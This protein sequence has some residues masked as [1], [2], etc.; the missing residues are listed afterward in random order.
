MTFSVT[1][2]GS[3]SA[4]PAHG[5]HPTA[6][7]VNIHEHHFL[8]DCGEGTQI[9][10]G[11]YD[12]K[13]G[14]IEQIFIS[15]LH[16]DHYFGLIGLL[17]SYA[18]NRRTTPMTIF[19]PKGL[20]RCLAVHFEETASQ[21]SFPV[22]FVE[23]E[24]E[25]G[26]KIFENNAV[27]VYT[28]KMIHRLPCTGFLF[29][30][31]TRDR[32][33]IPEKLEE[34]KIPFTEIPAI[35]KGGDYTTPMGKLIK[36]SKLTKNPPKPRSYAYCTDTAYNEKLI[37]YIKGVDLLY[38]EATFDAARKERAKETGHS[39]SIQAAMIAKKATVKKLIMG[40]FSARFRDHELSILTDEAATIFPNCALALEGETFTV[41]KR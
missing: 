6:Q 19:G 3:N 32:N 11:K 30:E 29:V 15:H 37:P 36:N 7:I 9:Q 24:D 28:M 22:E 33:V 1:I 10:F 26:I 39:T 41:E 13:Y 4:L 2:L 18:L 5:R 21:L 16:G 25:N 17:T 23:L 40:H 27:E 34:Y 31:K 20:E 8:V 35:K 12:V 14:K 38:H